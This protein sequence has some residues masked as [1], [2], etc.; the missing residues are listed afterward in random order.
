METSRRREYKSP[1]QNSQHNRLA[2]GSHANE[3]LKE[4]QNNQKIST[5]PKNN[6]IKCK[7]VRETKTMLDTLNKKCIAV[8]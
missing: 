4:T 1:Q 5:P 8:R 6:G 2:V 3:S 7:N